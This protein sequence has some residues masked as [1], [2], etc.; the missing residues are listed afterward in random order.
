MATIITKLQN[1]NVVIDINGTDY[2]SLNPDKQVK[3]RDGSCEI[4]DKS[5][6]REHVFD[7]DDV[8]KVVRRD[9]TEVLISDVGT[10]FFELS[11]FFFFKLGGGGSNHLGVFDNYTDLT[12]QYPTASVGDLAYVENSQGTAWLPGT[13]GGTFYSKGVYMWNGSFWDSSVDEIAAQ[14]EQNINDIMSL[15]TALTNHVTDLNNPHQTSDANINISDITTNN[16]STSAHGFAPKL[17]GDGTLYLDGN[18]NYTTP[19]TTAVSNGLKYRI[20]NGVSITI[21]QWFQYFVYRNFIIDL[22]A[23]VTIDSGGQLVIHNG[24]LTNNGSLINNG[25]IIND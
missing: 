20:L 5:G 9:G 16:V 14:L 21:P 11:T 24:I 23:T 6:S 15:Q 3:I 7:P 22:G 1:G 25:L 19:S 17:P 18:G 8:T 10:L 13:L 4:H 12:T 2:V